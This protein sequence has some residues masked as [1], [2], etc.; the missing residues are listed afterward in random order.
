MQAYRPFSDLLGNAASRLAHSNLLA[1]VA[2]G[3]A[4]SNLFAKVVNGSV[5][6]NLL[7]HFHVNFCHIM[8]LPHPVFSTFVCSNCS[9]SCL[10]NTSAENELYIL[11]YTV[12]FFLLLLLIVIPFLCYRKYYLY[13][14]GVLLSKVGCYYSLLLFHS[15][16]RHFWQKVITSI[17]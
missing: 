9:I 16:S 1:N 6:S 12:L 14:L 15:F 7:A 10:Q 17:D 13:V 11:S 2:S 5:Y 3:L 8:L 4:H